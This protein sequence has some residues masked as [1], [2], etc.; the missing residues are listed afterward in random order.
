MGGRGRTRRTQRESGLRRSRGV[1]WHGQ[2]SGFRSTCGVRS[3]ARTRR[4]PASRST[5][6]GKWIATPGS[7]R[8]SRPSI[9]ARLYRLG[10][11]YARG[12]Q[13]RPKGL[14]G[15]NN[16][17]FHRRRCQRGNF[18]LHAVRDAGV[19]GCSSRQPAVVT[20]IGHRPNRGSERL[21]GTT[22]HNLKT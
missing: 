7:N 14:T 18:L 22:R 9:C 11:K 17:D 4:T 10:I 8:R 3:M 13:S 5:S 21:T 19:H 15:S 6:V 20:A 12:T 2:R 1:R 16:L